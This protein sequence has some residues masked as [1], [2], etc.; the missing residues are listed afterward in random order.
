MTDAQ[1]DW[2]AAN[3]QYVFCGR[4]RPGINFRECGT[5]YADGRFE[6]MAPMKPIKLEEGCRLV[7][8]PSDLYLTEEA[9]LSERGAT[10]LSFTKRCCCNHTFGM[11]NADGCCAV[12]DCECAD[13]REKP[14]WRAE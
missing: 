11:H 8:V 14:L 13:F 10:L 5:L 7:G 2:M 4:P 9:G 1:R 6:P 12:L 3:P